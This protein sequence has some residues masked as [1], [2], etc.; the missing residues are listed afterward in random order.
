VEVIMNTRTFS[1]EEVT[2]IVNVRLYR[3]RERMVKDFEN[4]MK[5]CMAALHLMLYQEMC[6][7]KE[8]NETKG[9]HANES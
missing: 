9:E 6:E 1:K 3:E 7:M 5:R 2:R 4:R 8:K